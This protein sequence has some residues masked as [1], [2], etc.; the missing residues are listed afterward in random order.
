[1]SEEHPYSVHSF[2]MPMRW[3]YFPKDYNYTKGK[4]SFDFDERTNLKVFAE[5]L[6]I[7]NIWKRKFYRINNYSELYN[8]NT[9]F[10]AFATRTLFDMQQHDE[11]DENQISSNK[12]M[13]YFEVDYDSS[14]YYKISTN[15]GEFTLSLTG[16]SLHV[17]NTGVAILTYNLEN[18]KYAKSEDIL[19][20]N[21]FGRRIYPQFLGV[22]EPLTETTK[23]VF[24]A[25]QLEIKC[26]AI[27]YGL[28]FSDDFTQYDTLQNK[29]THKVDIYGNYQP[30]IIIDI[31]EIIQK[32]FNENFVFSAKDETPEKIR[33]NILTDDRMFFQSWY[34]NND[35][36]IELAKPLNDQHNKLIG[37]KY[38][39]NNFWYAYMYGD[40]TLKSLGI[41]NKLR[42]EKDILENTYDR[43]VEYG[44]LFGFTRDS[45][46]A[47]S[48]DIKTLLDKYAPNVK[49]HTKT[50]Y[51]QMAVLCLAQRASVLRFSAEVSGLADLGKKQNDNE[52]SKRIQQL[53]L[54]YIEFINKIYFREITPQIQGIEIYSQFQKIMNIHHDVK[55]LDTEISELHEYVT[56]IQDNK[57]NEEATKLNRLATIFLPATVMFGIL[58]ANF[59]TEDNFE[60]TNGIDIHSLGWICIGFLP[61]IVLY[62]IYK[63]KKND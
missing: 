32:L 36:A 10:H 48:S 19:K 3:D 37:F 53:Y 18:W 56:L 47:V 50:M 11:L 25:K 38:A 39:Q 61:S 31:P 42:Q 54:N 7:T 28:P 1:M 22:K 21:E 59:L 43:W 45:F 9:Y 13:I 63:N 52:I 40:K 27:N 20:I 30:N 2:M 62:F 23:I 33:F 29:E 41:A 34:G 5:K 17:Y 46:V 49:T 57:R 4:E 26:V 14:D 60:I 6:Q 44:T 12:T 16:I 8:E 35:I 55:D 15:D 58:G 24:L 51:Y